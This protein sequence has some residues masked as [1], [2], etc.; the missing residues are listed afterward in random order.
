MRTKLV[1]ISLAFTM[2][3]SGCRPTTQPVRNDT[4][5]HVEPTNV[6]EPIIMQTDSTEYHSYGRSSAITITIH[7][8][9]DSMLVFPACGRISFR[10]DTLVGQQ[11]KPGVPEWG[12]PCLAEFVGNWLIEPDSAYINGFRVYSPAMY[13]IVTVYSGVGQAGV[14]TDTLMSNIFFVL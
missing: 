7:N 5:P 10:I 6:E 14:F 12:Q 11:W 2:V 3:A 13:R 8:H 9:T 1:L 4:T